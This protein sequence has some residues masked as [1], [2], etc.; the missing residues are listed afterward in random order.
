MLHLFILNLIIEGAF[1]YAQIPEPYT[2]IKNSTQITKNM[3]SIMSDGV[4]LRCDIYTPIEKQDKSCPVILVRLPYGKDEKYTVM[5]E[6]GLEFSSYGYIVVVQD[7]RGRFASEGTFVPFVNER[8]DGYETIDWISKQ[9][10]RNGN[11]GMIGDSYYGYT[12][13]AAAVENHPNLKCVVPS[14]TSMDIY[15]TWV[16]NS[17]ALALQ[18]M[19]LWAMLM[20]SQRYQDLGT[21]NSDHLP[22]NTMTDVANIKGEIFKTWLQH[23]T[24]DSFWNDINLHD[25]YNKINIPALHIGGWYDVFL[26]STIDDWV[27]VSKESITA[28][29]NQWLI[30]GP[31][32]HEYTAWETGKI[33][34]LDVGKN[35]NEYWNIIVNF[36][37]FYLNDVENDFHKT[38]RVNLFVMGKNRWRKESEWPLKNTAFQNFYFNSDGSANNHAGSLRKEPIFKECDTVDSYQ[39]DPMDPVRVSSKVD[40]WKFTQGL[41][42]RSEIH[43]RDDIC[44]YETEPLLAKMEITGPIEGTLFASST[45]KSTDFTV[46]LVDVSPDGS[47]HLIQEGIIRTDFRNGDIE[48]SAIEPH[49]VYK[50]VVDLVATSYMLNKGHKIRVEVSSSNFNRYDRNLNNNDRLGALST[51]RIAEQKIYHSPKFPSHITLPV[52]E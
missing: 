2:I 31:Y 25:S 26:R 51:S 33:G 50:Y 16:Y 47:A 37:D 18:T 21:V 19:G 4:A 15:G 52:I 41:P 44:V 8:K 34:T 30:I 6:F 13:W 46:A 20:D 1:V 5:E 22:L 36:F 48:I 14:V 17:G 40:L 11:I 43:K 27:G 32:D 24:R 35:G 9:S 3:T 10:W 45:A 49:K 23:P 38:P 29:K 12:T 7:V 42:D 39:Y 28:K